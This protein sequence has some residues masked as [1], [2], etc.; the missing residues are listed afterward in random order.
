MVSGSPKGSVPMRAAHPGGWVLHAVRAHMWHIVRNGAA[1]S[2][3]LSRRSS[4]VPVHARTMSSLMVSQACA[5]VCAPSAPL[6][7]DV[8]RD[9]SS[10][11]TIVAAVAQHPE[12]IIRANSHCWR[13][14]SAA[15]MMHCATNG[16]MYAHMR[17]AVVCVRWVVCVLLMHPLCMGAGRCA[18]GAGSCGRT[19]GAVRA[20]RIPG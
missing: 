8:G 18:S 19:V 7:K 10:V 2:A 12:P 1:S 9:C 3:M 13:T 14:S 11:S 15:S 17:N 20:W 5:G 4:V 16:A 6:S